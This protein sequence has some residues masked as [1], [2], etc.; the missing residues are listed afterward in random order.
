M[1]EK[2]ENELIKN[3]GTAADAENADSSPDA[4]SAPEAED[5]REASPAADAGTTENTRGADI[6]PPAG[7]PEAAPGNAGEYRW[8]FASEAAR[9]EK[10]RRST[11]RR[12]AVVYAAVMTSAFLICFALL[13]VVAVTAPRLPAGGTTGDGTVAPPEDTVVVERHIYVHDGVSSGKLSVSEINDKVSP[14]V[15]A[16]SVRR[17]DGSG[18]GTGIIKSNDGYIIT[19]YHVVESHVSIEVVMRD[20]T[21]HTAK[22]IGGNELS[23][24]AVI[25][26]DAGELPAAEFGDS[27][28]LVVGE[29]TVAIGTP[30]GLE[31]A[32]TVTTGVVSAV[33]R[34]VKFHDT[35]GLLQKTMTLIQTSTQIN[36]GNSGGP[37]I[38]GDGQVIGINT[39]KILGTEYEGI[40]FAIPINGAM[41]IC[42][43]II[44]G[45]SGDDGDVASKAARL[46]VSGSAVTKGEEFSYY[47]NGRKKTVKS[48]PADGIVVVEFTDTK[49]DIASKL[50]TGDIIISI[51][52]TATTSIDDVR[53]VLARHKEGDTVTI[54]F[55]RSG[56]EMS[57]D[58]I[59]GS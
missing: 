4:N 37:L 38:N 54:V 10:T 19:N 36:P 24:I 22:Y 32:G 26:V 29:P 17:T 49:Y 35:D 58:V 20:G 55:I 44:A 3:D 14:S 15:V 31:Y 6:L 13:I 51:D 45:K 16:I 52:G 7:I 21:T 33:R 9:A 53:A 56:S 50:R 5:A 39:Y 43:D 48:A 41:K 18:V 40:G 28:A 11:A 1:S 42:D 46:G 2:E 47:E 34:D 12:G 25:K 57:A 59:L 8:S 27:D 30:G 23:D